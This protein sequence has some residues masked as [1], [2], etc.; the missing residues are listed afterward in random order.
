MQDFYD[1]FPYP[2]TEARPNSS[3]NGANM[4][5]ILDRESRTN[6]FA[7]LTFLDIGCGSGHRI[8]ILP[9]RSRTRDSWASTFQAKTSNWRKIRPSSQ[10]TNYFT[11]CGIDDHEEPEKFDVIIANGVLHHLADP[12][13]SLQKMVRFLKSDGLFVAWLC[14]TYGEYDRILG[15]GGVADPARR[16]MS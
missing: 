5:R 14:H 10:V 1:H 8:S 7:G 16:P 2:L 15:R 3:V 13:R 4:F 6:G 11:Q 9:R 12:V